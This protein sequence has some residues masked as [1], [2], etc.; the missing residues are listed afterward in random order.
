MNAGDVTPDVLDAVL[1][2]H[3]PVRFGVIKRDGRWHAFSI[4]AERGEPERA[5]CRGFGHQRLADA[6]AEMRVTIAEF[7][8]IRSRKMSTP[9]IVPGQ[10]VTDRY[11]FGLPGTVVATHGRWAWVMWDEYSADHE[12]A[13]HHATSL[14]P[15]LA[16]PPPPPTFDPL[17][18]RQCDIC[19][20]T[21]VDFIGRECRRGCRS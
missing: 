13:A 8:T 5:R 21:G 2:Q 17:P 16:A 10:R 19:A 12:P 18:S 1:E 11:R 7:T 20:G 9:T 4:F 6:L 3:G 15:Q 14:Q